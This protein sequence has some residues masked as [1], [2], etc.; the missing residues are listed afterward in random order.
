M[1]AWGYGPF[2]NDHAMEWLTNCVEEP[3]LSNIEKTL[4]TFLSDSHGDD[5][6]KLEAMAASAFLVALSSGFN[7]GSSVPFT[8]KTNARAHCLYKKGIEA[9]SK[10]R[11]DEKWTSGWNSPRD[12][13]DVL[14]KL[15]D[16][17]KSMVN[18]A[19]TTK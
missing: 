12:E 3:L 6:K 18:E 11:S 4:E 8:I 16:N 9:I 2:D 10:L 1:G 15:A 14:A 17:L 5:V 19:E 7:S 13:L